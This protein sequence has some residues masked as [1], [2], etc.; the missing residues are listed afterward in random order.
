MWARA[1]A[2]VSGWTVTSASRKK[3][4]WPRASW[5]P[6][7]RADAGPLRFGSEKSRVSKDW[8]I[9]AV[10]SEEASL[11]TRI[12]KGTGMLFFRDCRQA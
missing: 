8:A 10:L 6:R 4:H 9:W 5:D 3:I 2:M 11:M 7:F 12:S 1:L